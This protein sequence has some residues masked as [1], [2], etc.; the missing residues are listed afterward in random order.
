MTSFTSKPDLIYLKTRRFNTT[1]RMISASWLDKTSLIGIP[2]HNN[3]LAS[4]YG[5]KCLCGSFGTQHCMTSDPGEVALTCASGNRRTDFNPGSGPCTG[6][7]L[8]PAPLSHS[9]GTPG[10]NCLEKSPRD[11]RAFAEV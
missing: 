2:S 1:I 4:V 7:E 3:N 9:P 11:G 8:G 10:K 5:Q 6:P